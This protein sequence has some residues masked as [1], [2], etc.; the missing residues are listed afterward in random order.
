MLHAFAHKKSRLYQRYLHRS[1]RE[2]GGERATQED[3]ITSTIFGSLE[4][5]PEAEVAKFWA[6]LV[7]LSSHPSLLPTGSATSAVMRFWPGRGQ[8]QPDLMV[9]VFW[10]AERRLL[11]VELKWRSPLSGE[12]QLHKQWEQF[13][14]AAER[15]IALHLFIGIETAEGYQ[16]LAQRDVWKGRLFLLNWQHV[17]HCASYCS[18]NGSRQFKLWA[19]HCTHLLGLLGVAPFMGFKRI[20]APEIPDLSER[21]VWKGSH[22]IAGLIPPNIPELGDETVFFTH[23]IKE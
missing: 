1:Q 10:G 14:T 22:G 7:A 5:L 17:L 6:K 8:V 4:L 23:S 16:A 15:K 18:N 12:D 21:V 3:E 20:E 2:P 11:L 13:L 19:K 9:E